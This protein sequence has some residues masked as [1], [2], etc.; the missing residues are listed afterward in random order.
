M[1][2]LRNITTIVWPENEPHTVLSQK[3]GTVES[4]GGKD[5]ISDIE[6]KSVETVKDMEKFTAAGS[7]IPILRNY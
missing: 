6:W 5:L 7:G 4:M 3:D 2:T 1:M